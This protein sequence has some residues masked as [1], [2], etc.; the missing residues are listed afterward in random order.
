MNLDIVSSEISKIVLKSIIEKK[1]NKLY[2]TQ[3][4]KIQ[5]KN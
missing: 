4:F 5:K 2:K 1:K 3:N